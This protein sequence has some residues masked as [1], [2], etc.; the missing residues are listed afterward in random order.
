MKRMLFCF[1]NKRYGTEGIV[2]LGTNNF[3]KEVF[4]IG[5][6]GLIEAIDFLKKSIQLDL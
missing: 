5:I 1:Y 3:K 6:V 2:V 4:L